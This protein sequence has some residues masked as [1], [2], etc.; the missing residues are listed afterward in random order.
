MLRNAVVNPVVPVRDVARAKAF[1]AEMLDLE[2][3]V[4][5]DDGL[6]YACSETWFVLYPSTSAGA[7]GTTALEFIIDDLDSEVAE[8][9]ERGITF[10]N[11]NPAFD[12]A[13]AGVGH[14]PDV[15]V[16]RFRDS[17]GNLIA[18]CELIG[19]SA[20]DELRAMVGG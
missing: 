16:A 1:Y 17:E 12:G 9:E 3:I 4:E 11:D 13:A 6:V 15:R 5:E 7:N 19:A 14:P 20:V 10:L 8:L 18:L 2:P